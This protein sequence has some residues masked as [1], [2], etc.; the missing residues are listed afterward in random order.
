MPDVLQN[1][2]SLGLLDIGDDDTRLAKLRDAAG[3]LQ[4][5]FVAEP[6][7]GLYHALMVYSNNVDC[8]DECFRETGEVLS[9]HWPTYKN[10]Y[11]DVPR[12]IFRGMSLQ[13]LDMA[14]Q[15]SPEL[16]VAIGYGLRSL[17]KLPHTHAEGSLLTEFYEHSET[18]LEARAIARWQIGEMQPQAAGKATAIAAPTVTKATLEASITAASGPNNAQNQAIPNANLH[19]PNTG[20]PW[21][22]Q[23]AP[24]MTEAVASTIDAA[25]KSLASETTKALK[26][27][28][29]QVAALLVAAQHKFRDAAISTSQRSD[30]LWWRQS[31]Y[32]PGLRKS[33]RDLPRGAAAVLMAADFVQLVGPLAPLSA[34]YFL[35]ETVGTV[36]SEDRTLSWEEILDQLEAE[37]AKARFLESI[38]TLPTRAGVKTIVEQIR[39]EVTF[40]RKAGTGTPKK[41]GGKAVKPP[42]LDLP[43]LAVRIYLSL[44]SLRSVAEKVDGK[45]V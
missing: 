18:E 8:E 23:F 19:W 3:D 4:K 27:T 16:Q 42:A 24:K 14:T 26:A 1:F 17:E 40:R 7:V 35:R 38:P 2:L 43:G 11:T 32:C 45:K 13:A 31:L 30:L 10:R 33:Y 25:T 34:D 44:Q 20:Q 21:S 28:T 36:L 12:G 22:Q 37:Q 6:R 41:S 9:Q 29:D 15:S 39:D 5:R